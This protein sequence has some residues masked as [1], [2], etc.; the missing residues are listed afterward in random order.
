MGLDDVGYIAISHVWGS[1]ANWRKIPLLEE[2]V[3]L[4]LEKAD[5]L[6]YQLPDIVGEEWF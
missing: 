2:E 4:S 1:D 6:T 3:M 5:F